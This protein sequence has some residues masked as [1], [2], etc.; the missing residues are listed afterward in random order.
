M[1]LTWKTSRG[2]ARYILY[3]GKARVGSISIG[4]SNQ[5]Y[6]AFCSLTNKWSGFQSLLESKNF[7]E[8]CVN[9]WLTDAGLTGGDNDPQ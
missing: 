3:L 1:K 9:K 4:F 2:P 7:V 6:S 5:G 8:R